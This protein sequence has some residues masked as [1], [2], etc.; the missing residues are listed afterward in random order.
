ME[1]Y[2]VTTAKLLPAFTCKIT[3]QFRIWDSMQVTS[4][5]WLQADRLK[6]ASEIDK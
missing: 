4:Y 3:Q 1:Y 2:R 5:D 6:G